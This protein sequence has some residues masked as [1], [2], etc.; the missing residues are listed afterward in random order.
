MTLFNQSCSKDLDQADQMRL[1][2]CVNLAFEARA[3]GDHPFGAIIVFDDG[4]QISARNRVVTDGDL[5]AHAEL[6]AL[7]AASGPRHSS[8]PRATLY[9]STEPCVMCAGALRW[10]G[11]L[12]IVYAVSQ[13]TLRLIVGSPSSDGRLPVSCQDIVDAD[14]RS[15]LVEGPFESE[16]AIMAHRGYWGPGSPNL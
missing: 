10:T 5:T 2:E 13:E 15:V 1:A 11:I 7:R 4:R 9:S 12:R 8:L 6:L 16:R 14:G 3:S